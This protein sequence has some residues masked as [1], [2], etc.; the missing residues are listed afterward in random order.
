MDRFSRY[1]FRIVK[2]SSKPY[3]PKNEATDVRLITKDGSEYSANFVALEFV[4][5]MFEKNKKTSECAS[6][7]YFCIPGMIIVEEISEPKIKATIDDLIE[8]LEVEEFFK[9]INQCE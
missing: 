7:T 3:N 2:S 5:Y 8:N 1:T 4:R 6:G 9:K